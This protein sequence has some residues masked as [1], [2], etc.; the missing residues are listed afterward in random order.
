MS[1][2]VLIGK[3]VALCGSFIGIYFVTKKDWHK[4]SLAWGFVAAILWLVTLAV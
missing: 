4:S 3:T 2:L 1:E